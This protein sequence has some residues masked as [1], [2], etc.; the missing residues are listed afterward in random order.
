MG[1]PYTGHLLTARDVVPIAA[2]ANVL[3]DGICQ[4]LWIGG[5]GTVSIVTESGRAVA[6]IPVAPGLAPFRCQKV[7]AIAAG[8]TVW[9]LYTILNRD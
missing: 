9:A 5:T 2:S 7:T 1:L 4:G 3:A 8:V 6:D